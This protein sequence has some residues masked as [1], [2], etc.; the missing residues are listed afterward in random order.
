M[1]LSAR[2]P[3]LNSCAERL[4]R[5]V[6]A[7]CLVKLILFGEA[8]LRRDPDNDMLHYHVERNNQGKSNELLFAQKMKPC[9]YV[10]AKD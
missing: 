5:S 3:N 7:E 9:E 8:S 4:V 10:H 2:S 6:K 1:K